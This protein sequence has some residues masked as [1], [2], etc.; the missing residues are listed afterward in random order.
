MRFVT[1]AEIRSKIRTPETGIVL[2]FPVA[3]ASLHL[4]PTSSSSGGWKSVSRNR[5]E[6]ANS[7]RLRAPLSHSRRR[8]TDWSCAG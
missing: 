2:C 3:R 5:E 7:V 8:G 1:E 4:L 6:T